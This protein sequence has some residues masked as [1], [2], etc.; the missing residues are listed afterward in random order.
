MMGYRVKNIKILYVEDN[1]DISEEITFFLKNKVTN[2]AVAYDGEEGFELYNRYK[3]DLIITDIQM[4]KLNGIDMIEKIRQTDQS[5]PIIITTAF[6]ESDYLLNAIN[7]HVDSYIIKPLNL[8][9]LLNTINKVMEPL[10]L[11]NKLKIKN[12][13]LNNINKNLDLMVKEKTEKLQYN[14]LHEN[15]TGLKNFIKLNESIE[16]NKYDYLILLDISHFKLFNKQF[17]KDFANKILKQ[18]AIFLNKNIENE[19]MLYKIE[20]DKYV[21]LSKNINRM[22]I[23]DFCKKLI[24]KFDKY[25]LNIDNVEIFINF[26]IGIEKIKINNYPL[27]N[28]EYALENSKKMGGRFFSFYDAYDEE[29][30]KTKKEIQWLNRTRQMIKNDQIYTYYQPILDLNSNKIVK[31]EVLARANFEG[32][33][34]TPEYFIGSA[35]KLGLI[36]SITRIIIDK[37]FKFLIGKNIDFSIN[38]TR[39][40]LLDDTFSDFFKSKLDQYNLDAKYVTLEVLENITVGVYQRKILDN[41]KILKSFGCKIAIDDFGIENS[42]FSRLLDFKFDFI[43]LDAVFIKNIYLNKNDQTVVSAIV[44]MSKALGIKTIAE[45]VETK[46]V[47]DLLKDKGVDMVQGYYVGKPEPY[48]I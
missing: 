45:Y 19:M 7:L 47:A 41:L 27:I 48:L 13:E 46:E 17:G 32:K 39:R 9:E 37:S 2:L 29:I 15:I 5:I 40:D 25:A 33:I 42:N 28:A 11:K 12:E 10:E 30:E 43:K 26:S 24:T 8:K 14:S 35:Q 16:S 20:S 34:Y 4:P 22:E 31:Y 6:N 36:D 44:S 3:P 23:S 21:I 38:I 1:I 18:T